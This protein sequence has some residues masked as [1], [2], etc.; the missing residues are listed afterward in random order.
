MYAHVRMY[1]H[2]EVCM[3]MYVYI[4]MYVGMNVCMCAVAVL[5]LMCGKLHCQIRYHNVYSH[6][7][8]MMHI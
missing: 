7:N 8:T 1:A 2:L 6:C 4:C 3:T 5:V